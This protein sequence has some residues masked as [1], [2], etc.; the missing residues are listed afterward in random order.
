MT[1]RQEEALGWLVTDEAFRTAAA[2]I[3]GRLNRAKA[4]PENMRKNV[5]G[6]WDR[7]RAG[8]VVHNARGK[9][10]KGESHMEEKKWKTQC[11]VCGKIVDSI[12]AG[13]LA[14]GCD[15]C[16]KKGK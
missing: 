7:V 14:A 10:K 3:I 15:D 5:V 2:A 9:G 16:R 13:I 6:Y 11:P 12:D 8:E 1:E 4:K